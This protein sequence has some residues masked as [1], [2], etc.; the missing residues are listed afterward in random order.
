MYQLVKAGGVI[1]MSDGAHLRRGDAGWAEY[2][3]WAGKNVPLPPVLEATV[4]PAPQFDATAA[5][6]AREQRVLE[7]LAA[8]DPIAALKRK[9]GF[10]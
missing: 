10:K 4:A 5:G 2:V 6:R 8:T 9:A 3:A 7:R 1:R